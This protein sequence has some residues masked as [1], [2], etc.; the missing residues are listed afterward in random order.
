MI[1][2]TLIMVNVIALL[3]FFLFV[4]SVDPSKQ[5]LVEKLAIMEAEF[6]AFQSSSNYTE[7]EATDKSYQMWIDMKLA[8]YSLS[9]YK[10]FTSEIGLPFTDGLVIVS[11][12]YGDRKS[13]ITKKW[14]KHYGVDLIPLYD[15]ECLSGLT[16]TVKVVFQNRT[17]GKTVRVENDKYILTYSHLESTNL[18]AG[19]EVVIGDRIGF[20][21]HT[22]AVSGTHLHWAIARK[23]VNS[24]PYSVNPFR[25]SKYRKMIDTSEHK[26]KF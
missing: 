4:S 22:G 8:A 13:P 1:F 16:G 3:S 7:W 17:Y 21:G 2:K 10:L 26:Y 18:K 15:F 14:E 20:V 23:D 12:E 19:D 25:N 5:Q 24:I 6:Q 11:S 9:Q